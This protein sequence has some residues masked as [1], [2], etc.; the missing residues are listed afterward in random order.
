MR[1]LLLHNDR[2]A[3]L[4]PL[5]AVRRLSKYEMT[6]FGV[7]SPL[8]CSTSSVCDCKPMAMTKIVVELVTAVY[9]LAID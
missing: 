7:L 1:M 6:E 5:L 2:Q 8:H 9:D 3:I 4:L